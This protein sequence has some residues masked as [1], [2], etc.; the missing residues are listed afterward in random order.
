MKRTGIKIMLFCLALLLALPWAV[1]AAADTKKATDLSSH[2]KIEQSGH[3]SA[4]SKLLDANL[5]ETIQYAPFETVK[6]SWKKN[7]KAAYLC[8]QWG[9][10]PEG[11]QIRQTDEKGE[12]LTDGSA[13]MVWD[14]IIPLVEGAAGVTIMGGEKGMDLA[15][16]ALYSE[17][18]LPAPFLPWQETPKGMDYMIV[19]T[20]P[21]DDVLFMG[22]IIPTYGAEQGYV[23][24]VAYVTNPSRRR[25]NEAMLG[26]WEMG[27]TY[28][29]L[30]LEFQDIS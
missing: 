16:L 30:F 5:N 26:A 4:R 14:A 19:A 25:V 10:L 29:P 24:T 12:L 15:R 9:V 20:H 7:L 28:R 8:I 18:E 21:D 3:Q 11:V 22:G 6:L 23:G 27:A 1:P 17:G 2:I 13:Q